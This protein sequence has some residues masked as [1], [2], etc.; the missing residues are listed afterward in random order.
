M[1]SRLC[2]LDSDVRSDEIS[3]LYSVMYSVLYSV[4]YI[5][6]YSVLYSGLYSVLYIYV[7]IEVCTELRIELYTDIHTYIYIYIYI[8]IYKRTC[9]IVIIMRLV[10]RVS[11]VLICTVRYILRYSNHHTL[12]FSVSVPSRPYICCFPTFRSLCT[13]VFLLINRRLVDRCCDAKRTHKVE[14]VWR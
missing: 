10:N 6:L 7:Y 14:S 4:L 1:S 2:V 12:F 8:Y 3:V 11:Y 9:T 5:M 13:S